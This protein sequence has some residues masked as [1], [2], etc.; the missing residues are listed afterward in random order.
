MCSA[1]RWERLQLHLSFEAEGCDNGG[2]RTACNQLP[3]RA[4][5]GL[6]HGLGELAQRIGQSASTKRNEE[7]EAKRVIATL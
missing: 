2:C 7:N 1:P 3:S 6:Q 5:S 4:Q